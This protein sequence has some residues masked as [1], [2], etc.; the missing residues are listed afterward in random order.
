VVSYIRRRL[1]SIAVILRNQGCTGV[2]A[3]ASGTLRRRRRASRLRASWK[4]NPRSTF[5]GSMSPGTRCCI[6][7]ANGRPTMRALHLVEHCGSSFG[8][9]GRARLGST[10]FSPLGLG[11]GSC[12]PPDPWGRISSQP[13]WLCGLAGWLGSGWGALGMI[14]AVSVNC[15]PGLGPGSC[16]PPG[17]WGRISSQPAWLG[18]LAGWLGPGWG[19]PGIIPALSVIRPRFQGLK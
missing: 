16:Q 8:K 5:L 18:G 13:A 19:A 4:P 14:P 11:P 9:P 2:F 12:Q 15:P 10:R 7:V 3:G 1:P 6:L 17:P